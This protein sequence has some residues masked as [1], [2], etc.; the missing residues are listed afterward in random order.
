MGLWKFTVCRTVEFRARPSD[1]PFVGIRGTWGRRARTGFWQLVTA[2]VLALGLTPAPSQAQEP[3]AQE[4]A[5]DPNALEAARTA[6]A[7]GTAAAAEERWADAAQSFADAYRHSNAPSAA[8]NAAMALRA[9]GRHVEA[10]DAFLALLE[11][12]P[13]W[14]QRDQVRARYD[15]EAGRVARLVLSVQT[16]AAYT[17]RLD[18]REVAPGAALEVDA[19]EHVVRVDAEGYEPFEW[20]RSV[21]DGTETTITVSLVPLLR[22]A[23]PVADEGDDLLSSP[24]LWI[25]VGAVVLGGAAVGIFLA[26][27]AAQLTPAGPNVVRF[28]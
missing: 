13:D 21:G 28:D 20:S 4:R 19:G 24:W 10:R 23:P 3:A 9:Q 27:D 22:Q 17:V 6:Y 15:E 18:G 8:F 12:H 16:I 5:T 25:V 14:N 1:T 2:G 26:D 11:R 7:E